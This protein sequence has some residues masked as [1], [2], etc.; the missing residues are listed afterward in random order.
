MFSN[1]AELDRGRAVVL[2]SDAPATRGLVPDVRHSV[3]IGNR[4][5]AKA[6]RPLATSLGRPGERDR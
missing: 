5:A 4:H 6:E 2:A 3:S 1:L